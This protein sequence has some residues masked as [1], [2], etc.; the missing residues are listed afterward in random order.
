MPAI[1]NTP[2]VTRSPIIPQ[3]NPSETSESE[4]VVTK[5]RLLPPEEGPIVSPFKV[6]ETIVPPSRIPTE[7]VIMMESGELEATVADA[8]PLI[9]TEMLIGTSK[10]PAG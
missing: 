9:E 2:S 10:N 3:V 5:M 8:P 4:L 1:T 7:V 6:T